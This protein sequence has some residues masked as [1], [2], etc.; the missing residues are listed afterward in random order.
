MIKIRRTEIA[1]TDL[2]VYSAWEPAG[3]LQGHSSITVIDGQWHGRIGTR[4][5]PHLEAMRPGS[6]ERIAAAR[7]H[8]EAQYAE[9]YAAILAQYPHLADHPGAKRAMGE[10]EVRKR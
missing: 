7:A 5:A 9:A 8:H 10:I 4:R 3:N 1:L 2:V 6:P